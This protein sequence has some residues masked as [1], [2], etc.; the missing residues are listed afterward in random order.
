LCDGGL[1]F[2]L[3][4]GERDG[5]IELQNDEVSD[6]TGDD[7]NYRSWQQ[8]KISNKNTITNITTK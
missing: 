3:A 8:N 1:P 6:T 7:K 5:P 4:S 2:G